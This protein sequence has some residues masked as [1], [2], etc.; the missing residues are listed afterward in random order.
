MWPANPGLK[1]S[2]SS[3]VQLY[4]SKA[5]REACAARDLCGQDQ[6]QAHLRTPILLSARAQSSRAVS[7]RDTVYETL[8][9]SP[10]KQGVPEATSTIA[11][12]IAL[13]LMMVVGTDPSQRPSL[14]V[15]HVAAMAA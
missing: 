11:M 8:S 10:P 13:S 1:V 5:E 3:R 15:G 14:L 12:T 2:R 4:L 6:V 9:N 7:L